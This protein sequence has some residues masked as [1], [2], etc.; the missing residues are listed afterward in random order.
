MV[1]RAPL[2]FIWGL[3]PYRARKRNTVTTS[4]YQSL[5]DFPSVTPNVTL[6]HSETHVPTV[7]L[8]LDFTPTIIEPYRR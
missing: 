8:K 5:N 6:R 2:F 3:T 4:Q 1:R 7:A